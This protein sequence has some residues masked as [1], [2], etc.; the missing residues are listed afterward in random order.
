MKPEETGSHYDQIAL[1]WQ[2]RHIDSKYGIAAL[3]RAIRFVENKSSALD[4]GC[5][6]SGRFI[7]VIIQHGFI[8]TGVDI[9]AEM[10]A[11]ARQRHPHVTF[12]AADICTWVLP[13]TYDLISAWDSTFHLPLTEQEPVLRKMCDGLNPGGVLLFTCG[14]TISAEEISGGFEGQSFDYST[15]GM[16]EFLRLLIELGCTCKHLEY[17]QYPENHVTIIAQKP[18]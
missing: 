8:P 15:L 14:G 3:E 17:D 1:S 4:I 2:K 13:R 7:E 10:I 16:N 12:Y 5:G 6:S 18:A 11:L 9:S